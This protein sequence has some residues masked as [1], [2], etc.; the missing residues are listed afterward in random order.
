MSAK[1]QS[2]DKGYYIIIKTIIDYIAAL[3]LLILLSPIFLIISIYVARDSSGPVIY[4]QERLGKGGCTFM[5]YKFR[6]MYMD[7][8]KGGA[9][10]ADTDDPR[11][12]PVG[13]FLRQKRLD[14]LPQL[15]NVLRHEMSFVGPRPEREIFHSEFIKTIPDFDKRLTVLP[16]ISGYAQI[17]GGYELSPAEKLVY[18]LAYIDK[19]SLKLDTI[20]VV[21][22]LKV[23]F[24]HEG[25]R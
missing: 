3:T 1:V 20:I 25:A 19:R 10:W 15:I 5:L 12:T 7:A 8:E 24:S 4:K 2:N 14:E 13:K 22:T 18:D 6:S 9:Q 11:A 17:S 23:M 21:R 16:G